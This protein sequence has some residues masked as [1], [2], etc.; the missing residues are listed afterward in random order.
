MKR[1]LSLIIISIFLT[2]FFGRCYNKPDFSN[3]PFISFVSIEKFVIT[4]QITTAKNDSVVIKIKFQDGDGDLGLDQADTLGTFGNGKPN[5]FNYRIQVLQKSGST[6]IP[7]PLPDPS[8]T[9]DARFPRLEDRGRKNP[10]EGTLD[11]NIKFTQSSFATNTIV[12]FKIKIYDRALN[13]SNE[14]ETGEVT[15]RQN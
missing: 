10:L 7:L 5:Q 2:I 14:I 15:L 6:F 3:V 11:R 13:V 9:F 4:N 1:T 12:K 8:F